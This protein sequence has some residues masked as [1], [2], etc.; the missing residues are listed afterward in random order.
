MRERITSFNRNQEL[1]F[2][3]ETPE[4]KLWV[5][6][7]VRFLRDLISDTDA[8]VLEY[9]QNRDFINNIILD[10]TNFSELHA[11]KLI[12]TI[13]AISKDKTLVKNYKRL[14]K[15]IMPTQPSFNVKT[16]I[17]DVST[18]KKYSQEQIFEFY[19]KSKKAVEYFNS[20]KNKDKL[21]KEC[22]L[23]MGLTWSE[24]VRLRRFMFEK[25]GV[26][27]PLPKRNYKKTLRIRAE[28]EKKTKK[29]VGEW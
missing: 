2:L 23:I 28:R 27:P 18:Y 12:E 4:V 29:R 7:I 19:L 6:V 24:L 8:T 5:M 9:I 3:D 14:F 10:K 22:Y 13:D 25:K 21:L 16:K 11:N 1:E 20:S 26:F 17:R 15:I